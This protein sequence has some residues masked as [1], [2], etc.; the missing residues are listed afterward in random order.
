MQL[1]GRLDRKTPGS[2]EEKNETAYERMTWGS[3]AFEL[4]HMS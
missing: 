2:P 1:L 4:P 3:S